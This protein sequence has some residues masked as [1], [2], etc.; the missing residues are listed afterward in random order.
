M[1]LAVIRFERKRTD[2]TG[3]KFYHFVNFK[4]S[5]N[6]KIAKSIENIERQFALFCERKNIIIKKYSIEIC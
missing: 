2:I 1:K 4:I 3:R 5:F 6:I